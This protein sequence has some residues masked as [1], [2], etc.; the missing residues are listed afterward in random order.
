MK[1]KKEKTTTTTKITFSLQQ[2]REPCPKLPKIIPMPSA[3]IPPPVRRIPAGL[4][5]ARLGVCVELG[6]GLR[7]ILFFFFFPISRRNLHYFL[8]FFPSPRF[9]QGVR[10]A[11]LPARCGVAGR[12]SSP[13][14]AASLQP[15]LSARSLA[16][17]ARSRSLVL[18]RGILLGEKKKKKRTPAVWGGH[19]RAKL[20]GSGAPPFA[21]EA[22]GGRRRRRGS[23]GDAAL[24]PEQVRAGGK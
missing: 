13:R 5:P 7:F 9:W 14:R 22:I 6:G 24:A 23:G 11:A 17:P 18:H 2:A 12:W 16:A 20:P 19:P 3:S 10:A 1:K 21:G 15:P 8:F 4:Q